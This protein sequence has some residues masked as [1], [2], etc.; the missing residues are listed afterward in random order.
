MIKAFPD[1]QLYRPTAQL[2]I[3]IGAS[4]ILLTLVFYQFVFVTLALRERFK[5]LNQKLQ[6]PLSINLN[7]LNSIILMHDQLCDG[8]A[9]VN[10][11]FTFQVK[12]Y[13]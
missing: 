7:I 3:I 1:K 11:T 8:V 10:S 6:D 9:L 5:L 13:L 4:A 12:N 2:A